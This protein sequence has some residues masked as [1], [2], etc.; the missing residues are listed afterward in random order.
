MSQALRL[1]WEEACLLSPGPLQARP[2]PTQGISSADARLDL[3]LGLGSSPAS[4]PFP[5]GHNMSP[6]TRGAY[7]WEA[8][9]A[10]RI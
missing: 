2:L 5:P 9:L 10:L 6:E 4:Q 8:A 3:A 1:Q 7:W